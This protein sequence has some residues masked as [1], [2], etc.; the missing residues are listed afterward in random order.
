MFFGLKTTA[1]TA[2]ITRKAMF[3]FLRPKP[4]SK[5]TEFLI[6]DYAVGLLAQHNML[7][8]LRVEDVKVSDNG[9]VFVT[10][11]SGHVQNSDR[12]E[13]LRQ[14]LQNDIQQGA[15]TGGATVK[16]A[17]VILTTDQKPPVPEKSHSQ[18]KVLKDGRA[19]DPAGNIA[20][21]K[22]IAVASGKGGVGKSTVA[23]NLAIAIAQKGKKVGIL[24]ADVYGPSLP[25][26]I[27][28]PN[29][30]A[31]QAEDGRLIPLDAC[32]IKAMSMGFMVDEAV[33]MIWRGP[34][35]QSALIQLVRDVNWDGLDI[36]VI[37]LPPGTGDIHLTLAQK[38]PLAGGVIVSTPQ[39]IALIDARKGLAMFEKV[40]VPIL[41]IV[42]NMSYYCCP[43]CGHRA[44]IF[45]HGGA[46]ADAEKMGVSF[47][48]EIPLHGRIR[49]L[50]DS[51]TPVTYSDTQS[52][53]A[54]CFHDI[55][56][57]VLAQLD[58][59]SGQKAAS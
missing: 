13:T 4:Q 32:G 9:D 11:F 2:F 8:D 38:V 52:E 57:S 33:P 37:D 41:G 7:Q 19:S 36:L 45:G 51:G 39:D 43:N 53:Q 42:E 14:T 5:N 58:A 25:R 3:S 12:L 44:D 28:M 23:V 47:L 48:G 34:M 46:R 15:A 22:V 6:R 27:G 16:K 24:D 10:L 18:Q 54:K 56:K 17:L 35:L 1:S 50:S 21:I 30:K 20:G 55:A 26:L 40:A 49:E 31:M 29:A 59:D